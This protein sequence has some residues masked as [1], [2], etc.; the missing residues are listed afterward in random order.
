[1]LNPA[2]WSQPG[3]GEFGVS[4]SFYNDYRYARTPSE[5]LSLGR[6]FGIREKVIFQIRAEFFNVLNRNLLSE[7][8]SSNSQ[9]TQSRTAQGRATGGFGY[10]TPGQ[11]TITSSSRGQATPSAKRAVGS[12]DRVLSMERPENDHGVVESY[13]TKRFRSTRVGRYLR[14]MTSISRI[15]CPLTDVNF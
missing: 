13:K 6:W 7:P 15:K 9:Q 14:T 10:I 3:T 8:S 1:M 12:A 4:N 5:Q 11:T 2:A